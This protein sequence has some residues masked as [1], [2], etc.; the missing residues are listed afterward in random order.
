MAGK[1]K[2]NSSKDSTQCGNDNKPSTA[3]PPSRADKHLSQLLSTPKINLVLYCFTVPVSFL[4][5][6]L[7]KPL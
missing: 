3:L 4:H 6:Y 5:H 1:P 7:L 2:H